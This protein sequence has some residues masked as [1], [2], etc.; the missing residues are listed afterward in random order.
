MNLT[1]VRLAMLTHASSNIPISS[2]DNKPKY[3]IKITIIQAGMILVTTFAI[4]TTTEGVAKGETKRTK[5]L[6]RGL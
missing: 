6:R 5:K 2:P 1:Q 4:V 3:T